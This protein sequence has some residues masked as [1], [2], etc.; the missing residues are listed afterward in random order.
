M[1][2][3]KEVLWLHREH[4]LSIAEAKGFWIVMNDWGFWI[5]SDF[6]SHLGHAIKHHG[7]RILSIVDF[8]RCNVLS[9][10]SST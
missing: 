3:G 4:F 2:A 1:N 10:K 9:I 7:L 8:A 6:G 5:S